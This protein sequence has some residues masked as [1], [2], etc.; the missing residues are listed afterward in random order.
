EAA[1]RLAQDGT[2]SVVGRIMATVS[3]ATVPPLAFGDKLTREEF[4]RRWEAH[5]EIKNAELI[6]GMVFMPSPVSVDHGETD[7]DVGGWLCLYKAATPGTAAG[8]NTT[9]YLL[10][11]VPQ[12]DTYLRILPEYAGRTWVE[13][14]Y[15][16]GTPEFLAEIALSSASY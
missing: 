11:D 4:L 6:G 16:H 5:P 3:E 15:L 8:N 7:N 13:D 1:G 14:K 2:H 9:S 10:D 12:P